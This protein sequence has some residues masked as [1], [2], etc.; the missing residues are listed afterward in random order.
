MKFPAVLLSL[1]LATVAVAQL[2]PCATDCATNLLGGGIGGCGA[3]DVKCICGNADFISTISCCLAKSCS[4]AEQQTAID[5]AAALCNGQGV[6]VPNVVNCKSASSS[7]ATSA[8]TPTSAAPTSPTGGSSS[9]LT[10]T[11]HSNPASTTSSTNIAKPTAAAGFGVIG[12]LVA[13]LA[14]L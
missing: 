6:S 11:G 3:S 14:L 4:A 9:N 13:A 1:A 12:G 8:G 2:P 7:P 5:F 10:T